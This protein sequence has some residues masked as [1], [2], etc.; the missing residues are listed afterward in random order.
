ML[1]MTRGDGGVTP[2]ASKGAAVQA[3]GV[4]HDALLLECPKQVKSWSELFTVTTR[5][6]STRVLAVSWETAKA[7][8]VTLTPRT[9]ATEDERSTLNHPVCES[10]ASRVT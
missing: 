4:A 7:L 2:A 5:A 10:R 3:T 8:A 1:E 9:L 6:M